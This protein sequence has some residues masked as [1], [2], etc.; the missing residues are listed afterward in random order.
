MTLSNLISRS[1]S[2]PE[3]CNICTSGT[4][5]VPTGSIGVTIQEANFRGPI[6]E[7]TRVRALVYSN[8]GFNGITVY[9][10]IL[11]GV[12]AGEKVIL[13]AGLLGKL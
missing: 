3:S 10:E 11:T 1:Y 7:G 6:L 12:R 5:V 4:G 13:S 9:A 8:A 2:I